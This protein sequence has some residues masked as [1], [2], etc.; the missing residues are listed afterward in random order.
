[1]PC[2]IQVKLLKH[3]LIRTLSSKF[4]RSREW[5]P[6]WVDGEVRIH[7]VVSEEKLFVAPL[8]SDQL[9]I[10][11]ESADFYSLSTDLGWCGPAVDGVDDGVFW[12]RLE[13]LQVVHRVGWLS[14]AEPVCHGWVWNKVDFEWEYWLQVF[15]SKMI[16]LSPVDKT[17]FLNKIC[18]LGEFLSNKWHCWRNMVAHL[19]R[20]VV[21]IS[22][23]ASRIEHGHQ[24]G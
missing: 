5:L 7:L 4:V 2:S 1:M 13:L 16:V 3:L 15:V 24:V 6:F 17:N 11:L 22:W 23:L 8:G 12:D 20:E 10:E 19:V 14:S 9:S 18:D 21:P